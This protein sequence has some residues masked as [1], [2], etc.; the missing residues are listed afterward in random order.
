MAEERRPGRWIIAAVPAGPGMSGGSIRAHAIFGALAR[1]TGARV[2]GSGAGRE[3]AKALLGRPGIGTRLGSAQFIAPRALRALSAVLL[4]AVVD[5]HDEPV[6]QAE[7]LGMPLGDA[8]RRRARWVVDENVA[9]FDRVV[10]PS[11]T[12][13]ELCRLPE[14]KTIVAGNGTD[15]SAIRPEPMPADRQVV[16]MASGA[17]PGRGI[18]A[19][20]EAVRRVR[21]SGV[22]ARLALAL[23]ATGSRSAAYLDGLRADLQGEP[24][25]TVAS[26][27]YGAISGF[28]GQAT[29]IAIPHPPGSYFDAAQPVKLFDAMAAARPVV[30]TPRTETARIVT[31]A[32]AGVVSRGDTIDDLAASLTDLLA[33][34]ERARSLGL[35]GRAA[36]ER[37]YD[38]RVVSE[39]LADAVLAG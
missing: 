4:P 37:D 25:V 17:A 13:A 7:A 22:E 23:G 30:V 20:V 39:R 15:T 33:S 28:L 38:W 3:L 11:R 26:P 32:D 31:E 1:R 6:L 14:P 9:R 24:W 29:V 19:L 8:E 36:A 21:A 5:M 10:V 2:I 27:P 16:A 12:F 35:N 34:P 18:E